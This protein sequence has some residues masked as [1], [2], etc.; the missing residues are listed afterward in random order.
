MRQ[1]HPLAALLSLLADGV[2][3]VW[4]LLVLLLG[5]APAM[6][7][8]LKPVAAL[9]GLIVAGSLITQGW[10]RLRRRPRRSPILQAGET[11]VV[12]D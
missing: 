3:A 4:P 7:M 11:H 12:L 9:F 2:A 5:A 6:P 10:Q 1:P 8:L